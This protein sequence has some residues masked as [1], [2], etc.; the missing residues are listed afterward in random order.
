[1][2]KQ[3]LLTCG[4]AVTLATALSSAALAD[5]T[6]GS[7]TPPS[8]SR[9]DFCGYSGTLVQISS[10]SFPYAV[11]AGGGEVTQWSTNTTGAAP[12]APVELVVVRPS[13]GSFTV[14]GTDTEKLPSPLPA[15]G[16]A[17]Y[18]LVHPI[19][20]AAG[21]LLGLYA[22]GGS[23]TVCFWSG[24]STP[25]TDVITGGMGAAP[26][27][28]STITP[29][30]SGPGDRL[31]VA[32]VIAP[33]ISD[34]GVSAG[35]APAKPTLGDLAV[36]QANVVNHGPQQ[37]TLTFTDT[38]PA[39]LTVEAATAGN[40]A[41]SVAGQLVTCAIPNVPSG[42][43]SAVD[44]VVSPTK[45]GT[46]TNSVSVSVPAGYTD[47]NPANNSS[48]ATLNVGKAGPGACVVPRL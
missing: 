33:A 39:G 31:N 36:L 24:G 9:P 7:T 23:S 45:T 35:S 5:T 34:V 37:A 18:N 47:P 10:A 12:G 40:G 1:M 22:G 2:G 19:L 28:G 30:G 42:G 6:I 4:L 43:A 11:P 46:Y 14:V 29:M 17:T 21:D 44:V 27:V 32:A 41:C 8:G 16:I 38:V 13:G 25:T 48:T 3:L 15:G 20:V 26:T